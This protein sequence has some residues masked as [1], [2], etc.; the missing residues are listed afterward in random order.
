[1]SILVLNSNTIGAIVDAFTIEKVASSQSELE[2]T[3][4]AFETCDAFHVFE[5]SND[6]IF[7]G[8]TGKSFYYDYLARDGI[9]FSDLNNKNRIGTNVADL[10]LVLISKESL[11]RRYEKLRHLNDES[12]VESLLNDAAEAIL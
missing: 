1:V 12:G 2:H 9:R 10:M 6:L 3:K 5:N 4:H 11:E 7:T 8:P